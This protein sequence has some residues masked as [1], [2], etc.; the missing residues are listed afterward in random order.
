MRVFVAGATGVIGRRLLPMLVE[1]GHQVAGMTRSAV[2]ADLVRSL[3][4]EPVVADAFDAEGL[5]RAVGAF[6]PEVVVHQLTD[7]PKAI[8]PRRYEA[9]MAGNDRLRREGTRNLVEAAR[10]AGARR[11]VAQ[12]IAFAYAPG[13]AALRTESDPLHLEA[14]PPLRRSVEAVQTLES[15]VRST[16]GIEGVVLR[17]GFFYGPGTV[18]APDGSTAELVRRRRFPVVGG[19]AGVF[20]FVHVDDAARAAVLALAGGGPGTCNIVD[21]D[22]APVREWLPLYAAEL[23]APRPWRVPR[24]LARLLAG[25]AAVAFMTEA[26]GASNARARRELGFEP[27]HPSWRGCLS[28]G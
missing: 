8:D 5:A 28:A 7:I 25:R 13:G 20:S 14:P 17:Y 19:G 22:P 21:D 9:Q 26:A 10:L 2:R 27:R 1:A 24:L 4:A 15:A 18:Y 6:R 11:V 16:P 3:G 12:G 23:G